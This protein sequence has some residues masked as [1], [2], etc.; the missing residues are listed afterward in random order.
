MVSLVREEELEPGAQRQRTEPRVTGRSGE[1]LGREVRDQ[2]DQIGSRGAEPLDH[3]FERSR[4]PGRP[5]GVLLRPV[6]REGRLRIGQNST[7]ALDRELRVT[8]EVGGVLRDRPLAGHA[9]VELR[10][11]NTV[12]ELGQRIELPPEPLADRTGIIHKTRPF[13]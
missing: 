9:L 2:S 13:D 4:L 8:G 7:H 11:W 3:V 1:L 10:S 12:N 5:F 6:G